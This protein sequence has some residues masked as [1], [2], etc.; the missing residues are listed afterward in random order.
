MTAFVETEGVIFLALRTR[1]NFFRLAG[2][3]FCVPG[4]FSHNRMPF[5]SSFPSVFPS[6]QPQKN[7]GRG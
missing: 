5:Q 4:V 6:S 1:R 7:R 3:E 2:R